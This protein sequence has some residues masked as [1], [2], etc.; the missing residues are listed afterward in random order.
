MLQPQL[1][2]SHYGPCVFAQEDPS[3]SQM[4]LEP[5]SIFYEGKESR[6]S[7]VSS[8]YCT[9][10]WLRVHNAFHST[11]RLILGKPLKM[12]QGH[13][14]ISN[15]LFLMWTTGPGSDQCHVF[16]SK[17]KTKQCQL[18]ARSFRS[19][20]FNFEVDHH[21]VTVN[22][23]QLICLKC[24]IHI[25]HI[26]FM[27]NKSYSYM[28][29]IITIVSSQRQ[30]CLS[31]ALLLS[32][33]HWIPAFPLSVVFDCLFYRHWLRQKPIW[34]LWDGTCRLLSSKLLLGCGWKRMM[35]VS[36]LC[37]PE[38]FLKCL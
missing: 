9:G 2:C 4:P 30:V 37:S 7:R 15:G 28:I 16:K 13:R 8:F 12:S 20:W 6:W 21:F 27:E 29:I 23:S 32:L 33:F 3:W 17:R 22:E 38:V 19:K 1:Q 34:V 11:L 25:S 18:T 36:V 26:G 35:L 14:F 31:V 24:I 10:I 5:T